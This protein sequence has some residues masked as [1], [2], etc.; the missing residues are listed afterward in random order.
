[1]MLACRIT[2]IFTRILLQ[3]SSAGRGPRFH[4]RP[5]LPAESNGD[6]CKNRGRSRNSRIIG[7]SISIDEV[8]RTDL[9]YTAPSLHLMPCKC[10]PTPVPLPTAKKYVFFPP[11]QIRISGCFVKLSDGTRTYSPRETFAYRKTCLQW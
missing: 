6:F 8:R 3:T 9:R 1:M 5:F 2:I 4:R 7:H 10:K 11:I